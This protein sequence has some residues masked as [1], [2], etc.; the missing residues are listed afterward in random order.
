M[1]PPLKIDRSFINKLQAHKT[2]DKIIQTIILLAEN[3]GMAAVA[4]G[5]EMPEQWSYLKELGCQYGQ[6]YLFGKPLDTKGTEELI[7]R[8]EN[9]TLE[10]SNSVDSGS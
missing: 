9:L 4:E 2:S 10:N 6:G 7:L 8:S 3:L 5:I 1:N